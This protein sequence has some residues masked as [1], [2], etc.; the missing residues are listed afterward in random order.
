MKIVLMIKVL[1]LKVIMKKLDSII[2]KEE[3][4][5]IICWKRNCLDGIRIKDSR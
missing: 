4:M 1:S 5:I 2:L 3:I